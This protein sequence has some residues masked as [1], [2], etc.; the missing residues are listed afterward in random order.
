MRLESR[1][2]RPRER[3]AREELP[4]PLEERLL[5]G[6]E[7]IGQ[8]LGKNRL[9]ERRAWAR[10]QDRLDLGSE[11]ELAR[12]DGVVERLDS[13]PIAGQQESLAR[14]IP[15]GEGE[16]APQA[17]H[18]ALPRLRVEMK[19]RLGIAPGAVVMA[20][21]LEPGPERRVGVNLAVV[22]DPARFV[23]NGEIYNH[24]A[25]RPG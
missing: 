22:D 4:H 1:V 12:R 9:V 15:Q 18:A 16:H 7:A 14:A 19:Y 8:E 23:L 20:A 17:L 25:L 13:E 6:D 5:P 24:A 10:R 2:R 11:Q 21:C 3:P